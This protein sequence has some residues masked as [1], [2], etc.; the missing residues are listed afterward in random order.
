MTFRGTV[1]KVCM[2]LVVFRLSG[3]IYGAESTVSLQDFIRENIFGYARYLSVEE[4]SDLQMI[5]D[6]ALYFETCGD[7]A[8]LEILIKQ[9]T[10][11]YTEYKAKADS[12]FIER[13]DSVRDKISFLRKNIPSGSVT[14]DK[15][16]QDVRD[17][18]TAIE[19]AATA[20]ASTRANG[21]NNLQSQIN[22]H[23][24]QISSLTATKCELYFG[25]Y[26]GNDADSQYISLGFAPKAIICAD[27]SGQMYDSAR[28]IGAVAFPGSKGGLEI[29]GNGFRVYLS[30]NY[31]WNNV[32]YRTYYFIA[33]K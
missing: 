6:S 28:S 11:R 30:G 19:S 10:P 13:L 24:S 7:T 17:R 12:L 8:S 25:S 4:F 16:A 9:S 20:E 1:L 33:V 22:T 27:S 31:Y 29:E 15:L 26:Q 2:V 23:T 5:K 32:S 18:F 21:D 3:V 14:Q